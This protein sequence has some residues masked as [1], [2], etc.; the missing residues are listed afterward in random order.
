MS[1]EIPDS[2]KETIG[3]EIL[4]GGQTLDKVSMPLIVYKASCV[5]LTCQQGLTLGSSLQST[6]FNWC[7]MKSPPSNVVC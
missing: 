5:F 7:L 3:S 6:Y 4:S 2:R 1:A